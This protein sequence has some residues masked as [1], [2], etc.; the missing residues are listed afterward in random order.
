MIGERQTS[1]MKVIS[2]ALSDGGCKSLLD[3][4]CGG[5]GLK[6]HIERLSVKWTGVDPAAPTGSD[7]IYCAGA[8]ALPFGDQSF[9]A[10]IFLNSL[11][12]VPTGLMPLALKEAMRV[13]APRFGPLIV[14]EPGIEGELSE[15]LRRIDDETKI[16]GEAQVALADMVRKGLA[17]EQDA[18]R[19][20]R[21]ERYADF[22]DF[23]TRLS[24]AD[25]SREAAIHSE[26]KA[27]AKDFHRLAGK[28][29]DG[30]Y[31]LRQP[32]LVSLL[33]HP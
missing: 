5:G 31:I 9:D 12:H 3:I 13:L 23:T 6:P 4:G 2:A 14:I 19:Y 17:R 20:V 10:V 11:H 22:A 16:R 32:M 8:E 7:D 29:D 26:R 28:Q 27:L 33:G 21:N 15:V 24:A 30:S 1:A 18:F 25:P